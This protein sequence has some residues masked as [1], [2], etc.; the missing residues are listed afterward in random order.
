[1]LQCGPQLGVVL[2][3]CSFEGYRHARA[4]LPIVFVSALVSAASL[5]SALTAFATSEA[6]A[7]GLRVRDEYVRSGQVAVLIGVY[8]A[9]DACLRG[10]ALLVLGSV[11]GPLLG[12]AA[13][14]AVLTAFG[15]QWC[16]VLCR[17]GLR[18]ACAVLCSS[19]RFI[20]TF[21]RAVLPLIAPTVLQ[22]QTSA[23]RRAE[24]LLSSAACAAMV[25]VPCLSPT[26]ELMPVPLDEPEVETHALVMLCF[27][28][29]VKY[30]SF[31]LV[32]FPAFADDAYGVVGVASATKEAGREAVSQRGG[33]Q[34]L[35]AS[36]NL[37]DTLGCFDSAPGGTVRQLG[38]RIGQVAHC[39]LVVLTLG[40][41]GRQPDGA[42]WAGLSPLRY[43]ELLS[44]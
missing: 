24:M 12:L 18:A 3:F 33:R 1:M 39:T 30:V 38:A 13:L 17:G 5:I 26:A 27:A 37:P 16:R 40:M 34:K 15:L 21:L 7:P 10:L 20:E 6:T 22:P 25:L 23:Q 35:P 19:R 14:S 4:E 11:L 43:E 28:L 41:C 36:V 42:Y 32:A 9:A 44:A 29:A 2:L 8:F 31:A